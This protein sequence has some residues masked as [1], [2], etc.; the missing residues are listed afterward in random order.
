VAGSILLLT[1]P[2]GAGKTTVAGLVAR[3]FDRAVH[4]KGDDFFHVIAAGFVPPWLPESH[5][6][7]EVVL[8]VTAGA[9]KAWALG[10]YDVVLDGIFGPWFL[11]RFVE[12]AFHGDIAIDYVV[13]RPDLDTCLARA[14]AR[15]DGEL[16]DPGPV[17][18]MYEELSRLGRYER[19]VLD[20]AGESAEATAARVL[21]A[22]RSG[23]CPAVELVGGPEHV[24]IEVVAPDPAWPERFE[25]ERARIS[26]AL[27]G[28]EHRVEHVGSTSVPGLAAKPIVDVQVS[29]PEVDEDVWLA[30]LEAAGYVLRVRE[31]GHCMVRTPE[32]D[33]HVHVC[34]AGSE[35]ER[36]HLVFRDWLRTSDADRD[37]YAAVKRSLAEREWPTM[38]HYTEAKGDVIRD[39]IEQAEAWARESAWHA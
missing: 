25:A 6:Q 19:H 14:T 3:S 23:R 35:W 10:G 7:N 9:A 29:V 32:R 17:R 13:L 2:P 31:P 18:H 36:R 37:R 39:I 33:V 12:V 15:G 16:T 28:I 22:V 26:S 5:A 4:L 38:Q 8:D 24:A 20:T 21:D 1:G 11:Q 27:A 34:S 30:P